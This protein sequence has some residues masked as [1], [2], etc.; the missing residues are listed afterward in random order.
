MS[1]FLYHHSVKALTLDGVRSEGLEAA[2]EFEVFGFS[3]E[4]H[5]ENRCFIEILGS[6]LIFS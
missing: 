1:S 4:K 6:F 5:I 2:L 3:L